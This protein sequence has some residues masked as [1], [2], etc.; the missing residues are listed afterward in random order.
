MPFSGATRLICLADLNKMKHDPRN[1]AF[2]LLESG[3]K[4][5][6]TLDRAIED[7]GETLGELSRQDRSLCNAIVFGVLRHQGRLDHIIKVCSDRPIDR[8]DTKAI[9]LLRMGMFQLAYLDRVPDFAAIHSTIELAKVRINRQ[10]AGYINAVLRKASTTHK[11]IALPDRKK[12]F[13]AYLSAGLSIPTWLGKRWTARYGKK[14]T[15]RLGRSL[16]EIP[17]IT[18]RVNKMVTTREEVT[19]ELSEGDLTPC[20]SEHSP[21]GIEITNP[22]RPVSELPGFDKGFFQVQDEAAQLVVDLLAPRPGE[23][24]L[25][26]CAGLGTKTCHMGQLMENQ[27]EL[28]AN[29]PDARKQEG[30]TAETLRLGITN[31][32]PVS[33]DIT[34]VRLD[35]MGGYF[36]RVLVDAPCT[37]L[38]VMRR[39]PDTRWKRTKSDIQRMAAL[40]KKILNAAAG[41]VAPGGVL[42]YAVCSCEPEENEE[43]ISHFLGKRKDFTPDPKGFE[44]HLPTF[45]DQDPEKFQLQTYPVHT[46][47]DGFFTARLRRRLRTRP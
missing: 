34:K 9:V 12:N 29:D 35:E 33:F 40:Q 39:N 1:I 32:H 41:L 18:L 25:D 31:I 19:R 27:G 37:G 7:A 20:H 15:E 16:L 8:I 46:Q 43:V 47:M 36:D 10:A 11:T 26:A 42:V 45:S 4:K 5:K 13:P 14:E 30:L 21:L 23:R 38:G 44:T 22:G 28:I 6:L 2:S 24:I 3:Q 17:P